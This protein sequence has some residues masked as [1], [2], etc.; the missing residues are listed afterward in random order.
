MTFSSASS[1]LAID[2]VNYSLVSTLPELVAAINA[3]ASGAYALGHNYVEGR[4]KISQCRNN[5]SL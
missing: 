2:G 3:N 1:A 5:E 4:W